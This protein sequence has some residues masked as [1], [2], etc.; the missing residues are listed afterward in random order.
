MK[1]MM[2]AIAM[3]LGLTAAAQAEDYAHGTYPRTMSET[4]ALQDLFAKEMAKDSS[5]LKK[6]MADLKQQDSDY[7]YDDKIEAGD[8]VRLESGGSADKY[9]ANYL[10]LIRAGYKSNTFQMG[11][12]K[13]YVDFVTEDENMPFKVVIQGPAKVTIE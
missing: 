13:A 5:A 12:L 6:Y 3:V 7:Y 9:S 8:V 10:I 4:Q 2:M 11:Y 1:T